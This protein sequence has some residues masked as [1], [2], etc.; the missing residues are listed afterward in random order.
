MKIRRNKIKAAEFRDLQWLDHEP[1]TLA[2]LTGKVVLLHFWDYTYISSVRTLVYL[3]MWHGRYADKGLQIIAVHAPQ[4][5]FGKKEENLRQAVDYLG[6][7]FPVANDVTLGTWDAY[8]NRFWPATFL[9]DRQGFLS[10]Y[11]VGEGGYNEIETTIQELLKEGHPRVVMPRD[12]LVAPVD[13]NVV[14]RPISPSLYFS[15]MRARIGNSC[16]FSP[17]QVVDY[18]IPEKI[19]RDIQYMEGR[20]LCRPDSMEF[21]GG[22][23]GRVIVDYDAGDAFLVASPAA[24]GTP[25]EIAVLQDG[26]PVIEDQGAD[27]VEDGNGGSVVTITHPDV[28]HIV[29]NHVCSRHRLELVLKTPGTGLYCIDFLRCE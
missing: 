23:D 6:L 18:A 28:Y 26:S 12:M 20:F 27:M 25:G 4:F 10:A 8:A 22:P 19:R 2:G 5:D 1:V 14:H 3:S 7:P 16:G 21:A 11:N 15:Y 29:H 24:D 13:T 9:I 17:N